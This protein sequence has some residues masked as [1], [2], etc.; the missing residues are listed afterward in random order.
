MKASAGSESAKMY[1]GAYDGGLAAG[2]QANAAIARTAAKYSAPKIA[3]GT[4]ANSPYG[5]R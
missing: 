4:P 2:R 1:A 5:L 3:T